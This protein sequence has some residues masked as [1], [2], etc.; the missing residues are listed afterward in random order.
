MFSGL[1]IEIYRQC[2]LKE[3]FFPLEMKVD[4]K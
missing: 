3:N 1:T 4:E 2:G